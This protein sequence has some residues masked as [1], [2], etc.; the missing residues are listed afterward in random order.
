[1]KYLLCIYLFFSLYNLYAQDNN[2]GKVI[3]E[4]FLAPSIQGNHAGEDPM[5]RITVYLPA[6]YEENNQRYPTIFFLH[7]FPDDDS[8]FMTDF[9]LKKLFDE[10]ISSGKMRPAIIVLPNS[11]TQFEGSFYTNSSLTGNWADFIAKDVVQY[12]DKKFRTI[13]DRTSRG[14]T[15]LSMGGNGSLKLGMLY[16]NIFSTVY[17]LSPG[18]LNWETYFSITNPAFKEIEMEK[19]VEDIIKRFDNLKITK[20]N[21]SR[22]QIFYAILFANLARMYSPN[23]KKPPLNA[24]LPVHYIGDSLIVNT[25]VLKK[26]ED[27]LPFY[28]IDTHIVA[29]KA[30][31]ALKLDWGRNDYLTWIPVTCLQFSKKLEAYGISHFAEEYQGGHSN[32]LG[33]R[34]GRIYNELLPFFDTYLKFEDKASVTA[35]KN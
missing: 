8:S 18:G 34:D 19:N 29:L 2:K 25:N 24:D 9:D 15:G 35:K 23:E 27:N 22:N 33:G 17:A 4:K 1:M 30:L 20:T 14:L 32:R 11:H 28:M 5:R 26:W 3:I 16:S 13:P 12:I 31:T 10:A 21:Y 7:G 6:G